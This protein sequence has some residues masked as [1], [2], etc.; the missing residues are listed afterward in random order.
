MQEYSC[1][2]FNTNPFRYTLQSRADI[3]AGASLNII[4]HTKKGSQAAALNFLSVNAQYLP[5]V[6]DSGSLIADI[7]STSQIVFLSI[8][9][10]K[11]VLRLSVLSDY[12]GFLLNT[13][14]I[15]RL[16]PCIYCR[17]IHP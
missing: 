2:L 3:T 13:V 7:T 4:L 6:L 5:R 12:Q 8:H 9:Q 17:D 16:I 15:Y 1:L 10:Y 11:L 14:C